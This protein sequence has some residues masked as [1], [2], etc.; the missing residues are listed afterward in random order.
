MKQYKLTDEEYAEILKINKEGGDPVMFLPGGVP[1]WRSLA[2]KINFYWDEL[3]RKHGFIP[4]T[5]KGISSDPKE[6][7]AMPV[8]K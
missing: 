6:F 4:S 1:M 7:K 2:E 8:G 3:G 5:V